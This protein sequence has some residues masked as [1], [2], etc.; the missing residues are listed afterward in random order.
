[1]NRPAAAVATVPAAA[2]TSA[3]RLSAGAVRSCAATALTSGNAVSQRFEI[4]GAN[5]KAPDAISARLN[6]KTGRNFGRDCGLSFKASAP[7]WSDE[8]THRFSWICRMRHLRLAICAAG[9]LTVVAVGG[10]NMMS[11]ELTPAAKS[12]PT[13]RW[14]D[15][16]VSSWIPAGRRSWSSSIPNVPARGRRWRNSSGC[17]PPE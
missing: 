15:G 6:F 12:N 4:A 16:A 7:C 3:C 9:W 17:Y 14:P 2:A 13:R 5:V 11:Y 8:P 1:M 10:W